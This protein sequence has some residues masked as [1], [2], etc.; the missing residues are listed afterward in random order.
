M[1]L[2]SSSP[3]IATIGAP[4]WYLQRYATR[5]ANS[6]IAVP[7]DAPMYGTYPEATSTFPIISDKYFIHQ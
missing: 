6:R 3:R 7:A 5:S 4:G 2:N 1:S